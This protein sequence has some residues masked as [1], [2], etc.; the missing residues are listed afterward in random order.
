[1]LKEFLISLM[2]LCILFSCEKP[3]QAPDDDPGTDDPPH[4]EEPDNTPKYK[5][6]DLYD[7]SLIKGIVIYT[8]EEGQHGMIISL[9]ETQAVW[10]YRAEEVMASLPSVDGMVNTKRVFQ[11]EGWTENYPGFAWCNEKNVL[12]LVKWYIPSPYEMSELYAAYTSQG[13]EWFNGC[14]ESNG[15]TPLSDTIYWTS[16]EIGLDMATPFNMSNGENIEYFTDMYK[17]ISYRFRAFC[18]F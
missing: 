9:D 2:C 13:K 12:G 11:M 4:E 5:I 14:I 3:A 15:G 7:Q 16:S 1:M 17:T 18:T 10:S 6:G 8:D